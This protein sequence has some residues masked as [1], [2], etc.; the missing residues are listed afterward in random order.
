MTKLGTPIG[1]GPK[2]AMV[3]V[4]F[5]SVGEPPLPKAEPPLIPVVLCGWT[6]AVAGGALTP[7]LESPP[8]EASPIVWWWTTLP[9]PA[10]LP[11]IV[12]PTSKPLPGFR[13]GSSSL[14]RLRPR[15]AGAGSGA[16]LIVGGFEAVGVV[17]VD[18]AVAVVVDPVRAGGCRG[19]GGGE[20]S[21]GRRQRRG[22][23]RARG[24]FGAGQSDA[25][26]GCQREAGQRNGQ[27][28]LFSH[29]RGPCRL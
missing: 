27:C 19:R 17:E 11:S 23:F 13:G 21:V 22:A 12:P 29:P 3:T 18:Q 28:E 26:R 6:P 5:S 8:P 16:S 14:A 1:A 20:G 9:P 7:P 15:P 4:G 2:G 10:M 25:Q 24:Q